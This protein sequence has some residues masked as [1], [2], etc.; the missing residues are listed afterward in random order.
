MLVPCSREQHMCE[1]TS[2]RAVV[3]S[4]LALSV[5]GAARA[6]Q[7][8]AGLPSEVAGIRIPSSPL[9]RRAVEYSRRSCPPFL[10]NHCM[11]TFVFGA[12]YLTKQ[13]IG[14]RA[15]DA[16][17]AAALHDLGLLPAFETAHLSFEID[18]ANVAE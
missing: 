13:K 9:A 14:Y 17:A 5:A 10:F 8:S 12:L 18:G 15:D 2:R 3:L 6:A 4:G 16:F 7:Q 11:R 1:Q